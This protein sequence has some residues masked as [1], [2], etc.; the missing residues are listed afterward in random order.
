MDRSARAAGIAAAIL[1]LA[2]AAEAG[3]RAAVQAAGFTPAQA[4]ALR[5][6]AK[7]RPDV[8]TPGHLARVLGVRHATAVGI[9]NPLVDRGL[10]ER[11]PHPFDRRQSVLALTP[12]GREAWARLERWSSGLEAALETLGPGELDA[13]EAAIA[14]VVAEQ[15]RAGRLVV[16]APCAGCVHFRPG[17]HPG[18][19]RPH[20]CALIGRALGEAEAAMEC[21][22]HTPA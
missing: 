11:R 14:K 3:E 6:A 22:E 17:A 5:F 18:S 2:R 7:T 20:D 9:V 1:R 4:A 19:G 21:P 8:A 10:I 12:A 16:S 15:V 13:F